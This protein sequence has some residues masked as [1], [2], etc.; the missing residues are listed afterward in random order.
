[1]SLREGSTLHEHI[2]QWAHD[3]HGWEAGWVPNGD[4][5]AFRCGPVTGYGDTM[6]QALH[7]CADGLLEEGWPGDEMYCDRCEGDGSLSELAPCTTH[8]RDCACNGPRVTIDPCPDC[9][10]SGY[11][12]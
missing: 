7:S 3:T 10:G 4:R 5:H 6:A 1:M 12:R 2:A 9:E 8:D 11:A